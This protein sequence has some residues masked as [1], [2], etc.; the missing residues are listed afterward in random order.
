MTTVA[1]AE[2]VAL[3]VV[4]PLRARFRASA[5]CQIVRDSIL[6][7]G[8]ARPWA[9]RVDGALAGYAGIWAEHHPGRIV[10]LHVEP[11]HE[12]RAEELLRALVAASGARAIEWQ[13]NLPAVARLA[14]RVTDLTVTEHL[15]FAEG[16]PT[17][18]APEGARVRAREPRD[19]EEGSP[20]GPWVVV[21]DDR[22]VGAGG[23]LTHYNPPYGDLYMAVVEEARG[24]GF[25]SFLVQE[26]RGIARRAGLVPA[27]RCG[28]SN[29]ASRRTLLR[30]GMVECGRLLSGRITDRY[31]AGR[32]RT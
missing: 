20:D 17:S 1:S 16:V 14:E 6:P 28:P 29:E 7:R 15:L 5:D 10:E 18:L 27:A 11:E 19:D 22:V 23:I 21:H 13:S 4:L 2:P 25:G 24:R 32:S 3:D 8:L 26:L 12:A 31:R 30:A 9:L